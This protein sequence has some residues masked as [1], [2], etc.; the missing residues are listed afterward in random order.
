MMAHID[1]NRNAGNEPRTSVEMFNT[2]FSM[3][4]DSG[5]P[6]NLIGTNDF[7]KIKIRP[8]LEK[9]ANSFHSYM[10][11]Q[12]LPII[13]KFRT[14]LEFSNKVIATEFYV[15]E[16]NAERILS[17]KTSQQLELIKFHPEVS[18]DKTGNQ[19]NKIGTKLYSKV[20]ARTF[21]KEQATSY[22]SS[23]N[24]LAT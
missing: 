18:G 13:G 23:Q 5:S 8:R 4:V 14:E 20:T 24:K 16:G 10:S 21:D 19:L 2:H 3:I 12:K 7:Y 1:M 11:K 22:S 17:S 9:C 6:I 15:V